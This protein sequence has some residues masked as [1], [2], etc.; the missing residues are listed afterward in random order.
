MR[1][2]CYTRIF[3]STEDSGSFVLFSTKNAAAILVPASL[4]E[5]IEKGNIPNEEK[6]S[7]S[8]L[9]LLVPDRDVEKQ[10]M[11]SYINELNTLNKAYKYIVVLNLDCNLGCTYCFEGA[12]KGKFFLSENTADQFVDFVERN[13]IAGKKAIQIVFYGGEPLLSIE[14]IVSISEKICSFAEPLGLKY[15]FSLVTNGTLLTPAVVKLLVPFGLKGAKVTLDGPEDIHNR[16]RPF[17]SGA[18]S[19]EVIVRNLTEVSDMIQV[20]I[21]GNYTQEY[22]PE[23]PRL[24]DYLAERGLTPDRI[25]IVKFDPVMSESNEFAPPDFHDGCESIN[26]PWVGKASL[27]LR[28]EILRRGYATQRIIPSPCL[29]E[30]NDSVVMNYDGALYK[31]PGL[32]GREGCCVGDVKSGVIDYAKSHDLDVWKNEECLACEY[33]PLCFGGCKYLK[34]VRDGDM[35]GINCQKSYFDRTLGELVSQDIRYHL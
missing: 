14:R 10:E 22:Y 34:L 35:H 29:L 15:S 31:C 2:S 26:E 30:L 9:D 8:N 24:L 4:L 19:F 11:L 17:K 7:L 32:I 12:R 1:L 18:G 6:E 28:E 27:A 23:F 20:Q 16:F 13:A 3:P 21:G 33:L 25:P 5:D